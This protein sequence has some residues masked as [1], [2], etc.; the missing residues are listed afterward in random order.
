MQLSGRTIIITTLLVALAMAGG[1]WW[2]NWQLSR[3]AAQ[4]W[5][6][7]AARLVVGRT[8]LTLLE[9]GSREPPEHPP[10]ADSVA[11]RP[12]VAEHD[13]TDK[14]GVAHLRLA[15][16]QDANFLWDARR[17]ESIDVDYDW[18]YALRFDADGPPLVVLVR[19]DFK[20]IGKLDPDGDFVDVLPCPRLAPAF[21]RYLT[22]IGVLN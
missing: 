19:R 21:E 20:Q 1:A 22:D 8:P 11:R 16:A 17:R 13:L 12:V 7:A 6:P 5:G 3:Y 10:A 9:L 15:L 2:Y 4:Y 18:G 14:P